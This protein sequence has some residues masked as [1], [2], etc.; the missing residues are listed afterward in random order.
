MIL[1]Q[2]DRNG[3]TNS[4]AQLLEIN[5]P[6]QD[7]VSAIRQSP[8]TPLILDVVHQAAPDLGATA[9]AI[10]QTTYTLYRE[11]EHTGERDG[12]QQPY[13]LKRSMLTRAVFELAASDSAA[14]QAL[15]RDAVQ[16][17]L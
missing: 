13:Y 3:N 17:L 2:S 15:L 16:D 7:L 4:I 14:D 8:S 12:Y 6:A 1:D 5:A 11:F 9:R 10:P